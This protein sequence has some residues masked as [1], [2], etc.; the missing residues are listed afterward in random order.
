MVTCTIHFCTFQYKYIILEIFFFFFTHSID[1]KLNRLYNVLHKIS[2]NL[3][4]EMV[5]R[6]KNE[7]ISCKDGFRWVNYPVRQ[8][9][10]DNTATK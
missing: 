1:R 8:E 3:R 2:G 9:M 10:M 6:K 4:Y 7:F 5:E